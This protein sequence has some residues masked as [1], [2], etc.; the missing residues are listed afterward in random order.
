MDK[1]A[2]YTMLIILIVLVLGLGVSAF[3]LN[4]KG[5]LNF[6]GDSTNKGPSQLADATGGK[7]YSGTWECSNS[8]ECAED[9]ECV[10]YI[11][12]EIICES[13]CTHLENHQCLTYECCANSDCDSGF[14]CIDNECRASIID[15]RNKIAFSNEG[16]I[17]TMNFDGS[18]VKKLTDV[19]IHYGR[20][21]EWSPK[22]DKIAFGWHSI[23]TINIDGTD[24]KFITSGS[25]PS[26]TSNSESLVYSSSTASL[27]EF[28]GIGIINIT[29]AEGKVISEGYHG[30]LEVSPDG[31][32]IAY[33][34]SVAGGGGGPNGGSFSRI[35]IMDVNGNNDRF[36][37]EGN[38]PSWSPDGNKIVYSTTEVKIVDVETKEIFSLT[39]GFN[40]SWSPKGDK[41]IYTDSDGEG[42][43]MINLDG[44]NKKTLTD[45][46]D[47][48]SWSPI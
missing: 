12:Q 43:S 18:E 9:Q 44:T 30:N 1:R 33:I 4:E 14:S 7:Y 39:K 5:I 3:V 46:G 2:I 27:G 37:A 17:Y 24:K 23:Y 20:Y 35:H 41:I 31:N 36:I 11:C 6:G 48:A 21:P 16:V 25:Y 28:N 15:I 26:W 32:R 22:G 29:N 47:W 10:N 40:P 38:S 42:I 13:Y 34:F 45:F 8:G 19:G